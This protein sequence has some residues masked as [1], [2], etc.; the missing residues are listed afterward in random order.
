MVID[1]GGA[2]SARRLRLRAVPTASEERRVVHRSRRAKH[3]RRHA[4]LRAATRTAAKTKR[5]MGSRAKRS[6]T[7]AAPAKTKT[8]HV[9]SVATGDVTISDFKFAPPSITVQVGDTVVWRNDGPAAHSATADD[10]SFDTGLLSKGATG[11]FKFTKAGKFSYHCTPHP[12]MTASVTVTGSGGGSNSN[13]SSNNF[14]GNGS[15]GSTKSSSLP[16]T[17]LQIAAVVLAGLALLGAGTALRR[18][19]SRA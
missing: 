2:Y 4:R 1:R 5:R 6:S 14:G 7:T 19:L 18:R 3:R 8:L 9:A 13:S 17:G 16:H 15:S 11:S 10:G 12:F